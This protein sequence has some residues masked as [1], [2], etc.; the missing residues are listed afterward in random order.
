MVIE[1]LNQVVLSVPFILFMISLWIWSI[2]LNL[3]E[4]KTWYGKKLLVTRSYEKT[5]DHEE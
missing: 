5:T 1:K 4:G 2:W 3:Q